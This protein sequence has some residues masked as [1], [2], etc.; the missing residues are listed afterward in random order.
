M[1]NQTAELTAEQIAFV[2]MCKAKFGRT[3]KS[4]LQAIWMASREWH[5]FSDS[6]ASIA[7]SLRNIGL[8]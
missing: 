2:E 5:V 1:K 7:R 8:K 6:D 3:W 4:K